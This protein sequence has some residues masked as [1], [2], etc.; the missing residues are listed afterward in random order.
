MRIISLSRRK[1][2]EKI[3]LKKSPKELFQ[4]RD[5]MCVISAQT[6]YLKIFMF[7]FYSL[8]NFE[9]WIEKMRDL[10]SAGIAFIVLAVVIMIG[11]GIVS[12]TA[13]TVGSVVTNASL[14][15]SLSEDL[16][17]ALTTFTSLLPVLALAVVGGISLAY[18]LGFF[19]GRK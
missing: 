2:V 10:L 4:K 17:T 3:A 6:K 19:G 11:G 18:V 1:L 13:S 5:I 8:L 7:C 16:A 9:Q 14:T 12:M 15:N